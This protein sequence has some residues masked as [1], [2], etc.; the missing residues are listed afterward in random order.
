MP[1]EASKLAAIMKEYWSNLLQWCQNSG[2][3]KLKT[4]Q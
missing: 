2:K 3:L 4:R 1:A